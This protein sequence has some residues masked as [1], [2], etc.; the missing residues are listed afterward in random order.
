MNDKPQTAKTLNDEE[1]WGIPDQ[2][3]PRRGMVRAY[4]AN[5]GKSTK[6]SGTNRIVNLQQDSGNGMSG[7]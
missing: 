2:E 6:Q 1:L 7:A 5:T 4:D 3:D